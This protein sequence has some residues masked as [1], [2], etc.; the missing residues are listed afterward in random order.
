MLERHKQC[1]FGVFRIVR[2][3]RSSARPA[4]G[5]CPATGAARDVRTR[6]AK[7]T[8]RRSSSLVVPRLRST[9]EPARSPEPAAAHVAARGA[10]ETVNAPDGCDDAE[11]H[12][13]SVTALSE[14]AQRLPKFRRRR[15]S[16]SVLELQF[17]LKLIQT[18]LVLPSESLA[19]LATRARGVWR[20]RASAFAPRPCWCPSA[21]CLRRSSRPIPIFE[22]PQRSSFQ[23]LWTGPS[24]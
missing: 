17:L 13:A 22:Q 10:F 18:N 1:P 16:Y 19:S 5:P 15:P 4:S 12:F 20:P 7:S 21:L 24:R 3:S 23:I 11:S 6:S 9:T 2:A 8:A 14:T